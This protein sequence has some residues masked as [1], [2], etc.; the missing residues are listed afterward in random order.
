M[1]VQGLLDPW[2][3]GDQAGDDNDN[4]GF[5]R[6]VA[7]NAEKMTA[8]GGCLG[9]TVSWI[10]HH[11]VSRYLVFSASGGIGDADLKHRVRTGRTTIC[12]AVSEP[13]AGA[14]PKFM[15][16]TAK[17]DAHGYLLNGQKAFLTN[18]PIAGGFLVVAITGQTFGQKEFSA[19]LVDKDT[20]GLTIGDPM[21]LSFF[22]PCPHGQILMK[23][24]RVGH[25]AMV[26]IEGQ[27]FASMVLAFKILEDA[28]MTG[29]AA[30]A[31]SFLLDSTA[32][33]LK[34]VK[35]FDREYIQALGLL[36]TQVDSAVF[37]SRC[38]ADMADRPDLPK[39]DIL[40]SLI[41]FFR[42]SVTLFLEQLTMLCQK[43]ESSLEPPAGTL[44]RDLAFLV[45]ISKKT[46]AAG[47]Q[48]TGRS[49]L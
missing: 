36:K 10:I 8:T 3:L 17:K 48:K 1:G 35:T 14:H 38:I 2:A 19:F 49:L 32:A 20:P 6:D 12:F 44:Q 29:A 22:K 42:Q 26:G 7:A 34:E 46:Q 37:L 43:S 16:A 33:Q 27:A 47:L 4:P 5:C 21:G 28:V 13:D 9:L 41:I 24:C 45:T 18:G 11:L 23:N 30:G 40:G 25:D 39:H 15:A 31:M